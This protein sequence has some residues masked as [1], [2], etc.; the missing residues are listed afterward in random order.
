MRSFLC[1]IGLHNW[2]Y[3]PGGKWRIPFPSGGTRRHCLRCGKAQFLYW[4]PLMEWHND[5]VATYY[6]RELVKP[7]PGEMEE[8]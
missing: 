4:E 2:W 1:L 5:P 6:Y 8:R 3:V 7:T